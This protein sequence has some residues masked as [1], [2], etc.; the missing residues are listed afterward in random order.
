MSSRLASR[1]AEYIEPFAEPVAFTEQTTFGGER[2]DV[3]RHRLYHG[4][5]TAFDADLVT[6]AATRARL[7]KDARGELIDDGDDPYAEANYVRV[8]ETAAAIDQLRADVTSERFRTLVKSRSTVLGTE[9]T[10]AERLREQQRASMLAAMRATSIESSL[11][12]LAYASCVPAEFRTEFLGAVEVRSVLGALVPTLMT[13]RESAR[14][15]LTE[16]HWRRA[17]ADV[18]G[19]FKR[20]E[21][22]VLAGHLRSFAP[23]PPAENGWYTHERVESEHAHYDAHTRTTTMRVLV[24]QI[25]TLAAATAVDD[26]VVLD[27]RRDSDAGYYVRLVF[28]VVDEDVLCFRSFHFARRDIDQPT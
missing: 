11:F 10:N 15:H 14:Y 28:H 5:E 23:L 2:R 19:Q 9:R 7:R 21:T 26:G 8:H 6:E 16:E 17:L 1:I 20:A 22:R 3:T 13:R 18:G 27:K 12:S 4:D 24:F 25:Q